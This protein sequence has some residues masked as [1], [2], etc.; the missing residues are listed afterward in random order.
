MKAPKLLLEMHE[1]E[2]EKIDIHIYIYI[3]ICRT[4]EI[5]NQIKLNSTHTTQKTWK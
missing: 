5:R 4:Y 1:R 2:R 3:Y